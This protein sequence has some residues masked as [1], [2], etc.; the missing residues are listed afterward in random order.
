MVVKCGTAFNTVESGTAAG[1]PGTFVVFFLFPSR[2]WIASSSSPCVEL[3]NV[4]QFSEGMGWELQW[5]T[6]TA[7]AKL[8]NNKKNL[9]FYL[10]TIKCGFVLDHP[11]FCEE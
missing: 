1:T 2:D 5:Q 6:L 3:S 8:E 10:F 4:F 9:V 7:A 11:S